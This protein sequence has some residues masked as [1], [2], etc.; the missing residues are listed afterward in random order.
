MKTKQHASENQEVT[1]EIKEE[2]KNTQKQKTMKHD[3]SKPRGHIAFTAMKRGKFITIQAY[4]KKHENH[5]INDLTLHLQ[6][7]EK[8]IEQ[9]QQ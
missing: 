9:Q 8:E 6:Q 2:I 3:N 7:L 5:Q 4:L 1:E